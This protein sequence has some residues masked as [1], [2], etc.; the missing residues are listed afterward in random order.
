[1][2]ILLQNVKKKSISNGKLLSDYREVTIYPSISC[3]GIEHR[4]QFGRKLRQIQSFLIKIEIML[5]L[6][7]DNRIHQYATWFLS[8]LCWIYHFVV[9]VRLCF[10]VHF[11]SWLTEC[12]LH[13]HLLYGYLQVSEPASWLWWS[14]C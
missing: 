11:S 12:G 6:N 4:I 5:D 9:D 14:S 10:F 3:I 8:N 1:M 2:E 13:L 7:I